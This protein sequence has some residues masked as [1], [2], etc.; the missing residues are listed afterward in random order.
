MLPSLRFLRLEYHIHQFQ[1]CTGCLLSSLV[2]PK[3]EVMEIC[4]K[5][6]AEDRYEQARVDRLNHGGV[7]PVDDSPVH[8]A[9]N[10]RFLRHWNG[11]SSSLRSIR[12]ESVAAPHRIF[13]LI[14]K[15]LDI[16][17]MYNHGGFEPERFKLLS[18]VIPSAFRTITF[19]LSD[20]CTT[21]VMTLLPELNRLSR[22]IA[23]KLSESTCSLLLDERIPEFPFMILAPAMTLDI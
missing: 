3:L 5:L 18:L 17:H 13:D 22:E 14:N 19:D 10:Q 23:P 21:S 9:F 20:W 11:P 15:P 7:L 4:M 1:G 8:R 6:V 2:M 12:L 16:G